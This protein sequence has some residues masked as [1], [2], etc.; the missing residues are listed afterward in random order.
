V[1]TTR[2]TSIRGAIKEFSW[3]TKLFGGEKEQL[4]QVIG[5]VGTFYS[6][7]VPA[8]DALVGGRVYQLAVQLVVDGIHTRHRL[9]QVLAVDVFRVGEGFL[10]GI[11]SPPEFLAQS[12]ERFVPA[13]TRSRP[14]C[15]GIRRAPHISICFKLRFHMKGVPT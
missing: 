5:N 9:A 10:T 6:L 7:K 12:L 1:A 11:L 2:P 4:L 14:I 15:T 8:V 3:R 13:A